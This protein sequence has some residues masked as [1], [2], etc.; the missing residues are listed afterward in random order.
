MDIIFVFPIP[1]DSKV[2]GLRSAPV[3]AKRTSTG[4][5]ATSRALKETRKNSENTQRILRVFVTRTKILRRKTKC[6]A[7]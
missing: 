1:Q 4:R 6:F 3:V 2:R 7:S 5:S